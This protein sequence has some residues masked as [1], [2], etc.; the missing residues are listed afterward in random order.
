[1]QPEQPPTNSQYLQTTKAYFSATLNVH[2]SLAWGVRGWGRGCSLQGPGLMEQ[3]HS[4]TFPVAIER[5]LSLRNSP[6]PSDVC[7]TSTSKSLGR[8]RHAASLK[9]RELEG[10]ASPAPGK[11][12]RKCTSDGAQDS[13][14]T[15]MM[16]LGGGCG[17]HLEYSF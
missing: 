10:H 5:R 1:M 9:H 3:P 17:E 7:V 6:P 12:K 14:N 11:E 13:H 15:Q 4:Q 2:R 8:T 16:L